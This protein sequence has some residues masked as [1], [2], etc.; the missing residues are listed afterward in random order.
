MN[1]KEAQWAMDYMYLIKKSANL[2][3][4]SISVLNN[5]RTMRHTPL[6]VWKTP[7]GSLAARLRF[8]KDIISC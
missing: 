2:Y 7:L 8:L 6:R 3:T 1:W 5:L 4:V